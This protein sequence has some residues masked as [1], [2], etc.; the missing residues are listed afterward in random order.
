M[1]VVGLDRGV[2]RIR[3]HLAGPLLA[4]VATVAMGTTAQAIDLDLE[5]CD[6]GAKFTVEGRSGTAGV[7][8]IDYALGT[9][10]SGGVALGHGFDDKLTW[11]I[12]HFC[13]GTGAETQE[14]SAAPTGGNGPATCTQINA[15]V[16][17]VTVVG[18]LQAA[19]HNWVQGTSR[20]VVVDLGAGNASDR[21]IVFNSTDP[22]GRG[23][24]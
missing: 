19:D 5:S 11:D 15:P 22:Y 21:A 16:P 23:R 8:G 3:R 10:H 2:R 4:M 13:T 12:S 20:P 9:H 18:A 24:S 6:N 1:A 14:V 17:A 7:L